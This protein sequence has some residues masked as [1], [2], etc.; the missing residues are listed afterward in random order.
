MPQ[1]KVYETVAERQRAYRQ[2]KAAEGRKGPVGAPGYAKWRKEVSQAYA[3]LERVH[4]EVSA[5]MEERSDQWQESDRAGE[6]A[7]DRDQLQEVLEV[8][9]GLQLLAPAP[10]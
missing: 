3:A 10:A 9:A 7:A 2:R 8:L 1:P 5:W 6:L 4:D